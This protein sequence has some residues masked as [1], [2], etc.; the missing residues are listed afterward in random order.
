MW[1]NRNTSSRSCLQN[2]EI[3]SRCTGVH[4]ISIYLALFVPLFCWRRNPTDLRYTP[5]LPM[6]TRC[7]PSTLWWRL[8]TKP[9]AHRTASAMTRYLSGLLVL[10]R[11]FGFQEVV[12]LPAG[13]LPVRTL[14]GRYIYA[15]SV[16]GETTPAKKITSVHGN[17]E[18]R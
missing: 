6:Q 10:Q 8:S 17:R 15:T 18:S 5:R 4:I 14:I 9:S 7:K 2:R 11:K 13:G 1:C 3:A 16:V 12:T